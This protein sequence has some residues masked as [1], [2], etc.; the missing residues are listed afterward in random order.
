MAI[1]ITVE[2]LK[3]A[4]LTPEQIVRVVEIAEEQARAAF[5]ERKR[6]NQQA[7]RD[8]LRVTD[9]PVTRDH[10]SGNAGNAGNAGNKKKGLHTSKEEL[11]LF[12]GIKDNTSEERGEGAAKSSPDGVAQQTRADLEKEYFTRGKSILGKNAGGLLNSLLKAKEQDIA[13]ARS[14]LELAATKQDPRE[15]VAGACKA[16]QARPMTVREKIQEDNYNAR[17]AL[18]R[19]IES[20]SDGTEAG[21]DPNG[22]TDGLFPAK[23][24]KP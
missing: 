4:G 20:D 23:A 24:R 19:F 15:F 12:S 3:A 16:R 13:L 6:V 5:L 7:Y 17:Q 9:Q 2:T 18:R 8:R 14:T 11:T 1:T 10:F 21:G 22:S